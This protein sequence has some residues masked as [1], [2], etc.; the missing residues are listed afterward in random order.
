M[1]SEPSFIAVRRSRVVCNSSNQSPP[2]VVTLGVNWLVFAVIIT[3]KVNTQKEDNQYSVAR[4][5]VQYSHKDTRLKIR[6]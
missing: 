4:T 1:F 2:P 5:V 6:H 3:C